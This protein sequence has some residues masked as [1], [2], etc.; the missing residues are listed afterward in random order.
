[1][2]GV[3]TVADLIVGLNPQ[4]RRFLRAWT[5]PNGIQLVTKRAGRC[6]RWWAL[7]GCGRRV[8][9]LYRRP[10]QASATWSCR[11]CSQLQYSSRLHSREHMSRRVLAPRRQI[12][13]KHYYEQQ[14]RS[15]K[16]AARVNAWWAANRD[17]LLERMAQIVAANDREADRA[18]AWLREQFQHPRPIVAAHIETARSLSPELLEILRRLNAVTA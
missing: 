15:V 8:E 17:S 14:C 11:R 16:A 10:D 7:C 13:A 6:R 12:S 5:S 4:K 9:A 18:A 1:M 3:V 2:G